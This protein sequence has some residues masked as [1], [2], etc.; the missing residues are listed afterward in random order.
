M[1]ISTHL[2]ATLLP[3]R[4]ALL[5]QSRGRPLEHTFLTTRELC[6][7]WVR[8]LDHVLLPGHHLEVAHSAIPLFAREVPSLALVACRRALVVE[9][10][11]WDVL[12]VTMLTV[13]E[14][15][16]GEAVDEPLLPRDMPRA[17][18]AG[19]GALL[20]LDLGGPSKC[21]PTGVCFQMTACLF[22]N[23]CLPA[24]QLACGPT[25]CKCGT[26][27]R[28][29]G[30]QNAKEISRR[31]QSESAC[32]LGPRDRRPFWGD[33]RATIACRIFPNPEGRIS[34]PS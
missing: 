33:A 2:Q 20:R 27:E 23:A 19:A 10:L 28:A 12:R 32:A 30:P 22:P 18:G 13:A 15:P 3:T 24:G 21:L 1:P 14:A 9:R 5:A 6:L 4:G 34:E 11:P 16:G 17:R 26:H 31:R 29:H 8:V 7:T 25:I